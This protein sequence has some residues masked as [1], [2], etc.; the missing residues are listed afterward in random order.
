MTVMLQRE[1][2]ERIGARP[3]GKDY[4][5]LS[6]LVQFYCEVDRLFEVPSGAFRP[7]PKVHSS[8]V[9]LRTRVKPAVVVSDESLF[10]TLIQVIFSQRRKTILN[11][12]RA[13]LDRLGLAGIDQLEASL[14]GCGIDI[15][16]RAET[17]AISE[18]AQ[19]SDGVAEL[20]KL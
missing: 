10:L 16:R 9:R 1:V 13:G 6:V 20:K 12:L 4:G 14:S 18:I 3:G 11:N 17:L 2:V 5:Y 7:A 8:V 15:Q 19:L